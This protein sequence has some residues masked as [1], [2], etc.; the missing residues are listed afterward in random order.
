MHILNPM[1]PEDLL[2]PTPSGVCCKRAGFHIDPTRPV[3][4]AIITHGHSD[5][6][7]AGHRHVLATAETLAIMKLRYGDNFARSTQVIRH[8]EAL[9]LDGVTVTF[10]PAGHVL[11]SAQI[12]VSHKD[13][14]IVASG[15]YKNVTEP[16]CTPFELVP[17]DVFITEATF[18]L[19][20]FR[21]G[22]P[23]AEIGKLL[24]SIDIFPE[25]AHLVGAYSL[26][27]AQRVIALIR[28]AGF[29][30]PIYLHGAMEKITRFY[31]SCGIDLGELRGVSGAKKADLAGTVTLCPP[32]AL[33]E[34]WSR[35]FPDPVSSFA[36]GWMRVRARARQAH[37]ELPLVI[38]DHADWDGLTETIVA[39]GASEI[40]VTHGQE[41]A[42]VHW[43]VQRG[44]KARPLDIVGYGDEEDE[45]TATDESGPQ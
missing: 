20:V 27:K 15:D 12:A 17:C 37:A 34:V 16:T 26:G 36:S 19:P 42:L 35:R 18:G 21:H 14:K 39:T 3:D 33:K 1:R 13:M 23:D 30:K 24:H 7:R 41:D 32:S 28:K 40:W 43:S 31:E 22:D 2:T 5:H 9:N 45:A 8:G 11:G 44:L 10:H 29:D 38:S 4:K 6:A 25:R